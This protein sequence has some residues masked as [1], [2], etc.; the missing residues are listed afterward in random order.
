MKKRTIYTLPKDTEIT[1]DIIA[2]I[3]AD[4]KEYIEIFTKLESYVDDAPE[5]DRLAPNELLTINNFADY[6]TSVNVGYLLGNPVDYKATDNTNIDVVIDAFRS[7]TI[8]DLDA[9]L[10]TDCSMFGQAFEN[11]YVDEETTTLSAKLSVFNT[12]VV[13][14]NTFKH[15]KLFA[16]Y[17][18]PEVQNNG[19][20]S[21]T[22]Y[23]ITIWTP[24]KTLQRKLKGKQMEEIENVPDVDHYFGNVPVIHYFNNKRLKGDYEPVI[25]LID[26]YN[27]LQSDRVL[28]REK[29]VDAILGFYGMKVTEEDME[30]IKE[31]RAIGMPE[32]S[33]AEY[34][35]KNLDESGADVLRKTLAADIHKFS[36]TPDLTD[37]TF[38]NSPSGVSILYKLLAF[39]QNV[40]TKERHFELGLKERFGLYMSV[41]NKQS[42]LSNKLQLKDLDVVFRRA[43]PKND[44]ETSQIINNLDGTVDQETLIGQLSFVNDASEVVKKAKAERDANMP[45]GNFGTNN[46][47]KDNV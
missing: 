34:I 1:G 45:V 44:Y 28:D 2:K 37:E 36:K 15:S 40:K 30:S 19:T 33:K 22:D 32:N 11:V 7:Q 38:G 6:I 43:L 27:I 39:E 24:T 8:Y 12:V 25:S 17:Y 3:I 18:S 20:L 21:D 42:K 10:E 23:D 35:V 13:Y 41:L 46:F 31:N 26:A 5:M 4:N 16:V 14:D 9:D 47:D 29:L